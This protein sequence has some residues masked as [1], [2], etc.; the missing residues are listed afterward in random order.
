MGKDKYKFKGTGTDINPLM[1]ESKKNAR[2]RLDF[3]VQ[4][5]KIK[6]EILNNAI[7]HNDIFFYGLNPHAL[8]RNAQI[9]FEERHVK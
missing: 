5:E 4:M 9:V 8:Q 3:T 1:D 6:K 2:Y 7:K